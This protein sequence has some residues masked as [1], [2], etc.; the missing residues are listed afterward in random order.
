MRSGMSSP[1]SRRS[2]SRGVTAQGRVAGAPNPLLR[3]TQSPDRCVLAP[4]EAHTRAGV[5]VHP[6]ARTLSTRFH[7]GG[8]ARRNV[9]SRDDHGHTDTPICPA[10]HD[11]TVMSLQ[12]ALRLFTSQYLRAV[13]AEGRFGHDKSSAARGRSCNREGG[14]RF[15]VTSL[16]LRT[17]PNATSD[18]SSEP[19]SCGAS[20]LTPP[21]DGLSGPVDR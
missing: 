5:R 6:L 1:C 15:L 14:A 10:T 4:R 11:S 7:N 9:A 12:K 3:T 8:N 13:L 2:R 18:P 20:P 16:L 21:T 17:V 19:G